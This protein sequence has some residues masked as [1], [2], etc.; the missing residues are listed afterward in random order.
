MMLTDLGKIN[1]LADRLTKVQEALETIVNGD[2]VRAAIDYGVNE[3]TVYF[4]ITQEE[5]IDFFNILKLAI[6]NHLNRLGVSMPPVA[7]RK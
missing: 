6:I 4:P 5:A 3:S 1:A 2:K 7:E